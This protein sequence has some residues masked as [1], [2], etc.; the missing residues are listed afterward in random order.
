MHRYFTVRASHLL[1]Q[2]YRRLTDR[3]TCGEN[4]DL[5]LC[6]IPITSFGAKLHLPADWKVKR[7]NKHMQ[8]GELA[9]RADVSAKTIRYY[10]A[11]GI[12]SEP[13][14]TA[15]GYRDYDESAL[16]RLQFIKAAQAVS[17]SLG[18]IREIIAFR[19][20]GETPCA[21]VT[22]LMNQRVRTL[23]EHISGLEQMRTELQ[24]LLEKAKTLPDACGDTYCHI[25]ESARR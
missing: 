10:E 14:R 16:E 5:P 11:I 24:N 18:E 7:Y 12:V 15:S 20:R 25:I 23:S 6:H 22:D 2:R 19:D 21:H 4:L 3:A 9:K 1:D 17:L 13:E 8:I